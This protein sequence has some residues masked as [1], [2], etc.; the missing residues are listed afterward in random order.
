MRLT[1]TVF[2]R[3]F[4]AHDDATSASVR[5]V[6]R[7]D[8]DVR[9][10]HDGMKQGCRRGKVTELFI[11]FMFE[12]SP[13]IQQDRAPFRA[14]SFS[15]IQLALAAAPRLRLETTAAEETRSGNPSRASPTFANLNNARP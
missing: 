9:D 12:R 5:D 2:N 11:L 6:N 7:A 10:D 15:I 1:Q 14:R 8:G 13:L 4:V 3:K